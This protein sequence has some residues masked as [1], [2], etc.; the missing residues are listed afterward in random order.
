[1]TETRIRGQEVSIRITRANRI[2]TTLTA[3]KDFTV[4]WDFASSEEGYLGETTMR[5]DMIFNGMSGSMTIDAEG[6]EMLLFI[7]FLKQKA[8]RKID[9]NENQVN[10]TARFTFPNGQT[11]RL[12]IRDMEFDGVPFA[13]GSR[14]AYVN[15]TFP[16]K[17][18]DS[19]VLTV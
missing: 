4:Q 14:D 18:E 9:I 8:Q 17:A 19:R 5:K 13:A 6:Q 7:E 11:P 10:A 1:M 2:E 15:G 3:I 12:L 16:W